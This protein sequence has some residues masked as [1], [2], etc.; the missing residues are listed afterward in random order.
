MRNICSFMEN[1]HHKNECNYIFIK[2]FSINTI[3]VK[4]TI[5]PNDFLNES[6]KAF[7]SILIDKERNPSDFQNNAFDS[8]KE[9]PELNDILLS[10]KGKDQ[11]NTLKNNP[12]NEKNIT[13]KEYLEGELV[14]ESSS[15]KEVKENQ[16]KKTNHQTHENIKFDKNNINNH[17]FDHQN[18][19]FNETTNSKV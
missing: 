16:H 4:Q 1:P 11:P 13:E 5:I 14:S 10:L 2:L 19:F 6:S 15:E 9:M 7:S 8:D 17:N 18:K 12:I 3:D